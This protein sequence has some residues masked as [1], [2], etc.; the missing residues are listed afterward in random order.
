MQIIRARC[1][2]VDIR[3]VLRLRGL[4]DSQTQILAGES[5][6]PAYAG[7]KANICSFDVNIKKLYTFVFLFFKGEFEGCVERT[8]KTHFHQPVFAFGSPL[9]L[10]NVKQA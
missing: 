6:F 5:G 7:F 2:N 10:S 8:N 9:V 4:K 1:T 3:L